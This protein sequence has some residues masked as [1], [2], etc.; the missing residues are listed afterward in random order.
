MSGR[1]ILLIL[2]VTAVLVTTV[3]I[4]AGLALAADDVTANAPVQARGSQ[5]AVLKQ[6]CVNPAPPAPPKGP[7]RG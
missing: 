6:D 1:R 7:P 2:T 3:L 5:C 4:W